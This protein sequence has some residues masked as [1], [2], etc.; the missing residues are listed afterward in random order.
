MSLNK[1]FFR[2]IHYPFL[3]FKKKKDL[4]LNVFL[5]LF[6]LI[7]RFPIFICMTAYSI[8]KEKRKLDY[9]LSLGFKNFV[10]FNFLN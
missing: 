6:N 10:L 1:I 5:F 8:Y 4:F 2:Y 9:F 7:A 3:F